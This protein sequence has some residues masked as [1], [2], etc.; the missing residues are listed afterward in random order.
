M[1][2]PFADS[3]ASVRPAS[4]RG[5]H[6]SAPPIPA[7]DGERLM[8][9]RVHRDEAAFHEVVRRHAPLVWGVCWQV[10]RHR[11]DVEDA[12]Q[13]TFLILARKASSIRAADSAA[14]WLYRVAFRT[15]LATRQRRRRL[16]MEPL[17]ADPPAPL[18][19]Q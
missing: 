19:D 2:P 1:T 15:A 12:F 4:G 17:A 5:S 3:T 10:L 13:A 7:T 18:E 11:E 8:R 16:G 6:A 9:F 14:G